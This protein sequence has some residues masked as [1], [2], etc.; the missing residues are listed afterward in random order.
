MNIVYTY[1]HNFTIIHDLVYHGTLNHISVHR[2]VENVQKH[3]LMHMHAPVAVDA[4][5]F[6][7]N[8]YQLVKRD[9]IHCC[10]PSLFIGSI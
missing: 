5:S 7:Y 2:H 3:C 4:D 10:V 6:T 1:A 8:I 9:N